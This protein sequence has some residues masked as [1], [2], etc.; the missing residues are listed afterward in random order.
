VP[1]TPDGYPFPDPTEPV[2]DGAGDIQ[3]LALTLRP[4]G[5]A[6][7]GQAP[8]VGTAP[9]ADEFWKVRQL[10]YNY[11]IGTDGN[12]IARVPTSFTK[13]IMWAGASNTDP[14]NGVGLFL[15]VP[16]YSTPA[17]LALW[18]YKRDG[19]AAIN[20]VTSMTCMIIGM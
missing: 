5:Q 7:G 6:F 12:G 17:E 18:I 16:A 3:Q 19:T 13:C 8:L 4:N 20:F 14:G 11:A 2:R 15:P 10:I 9:A 1:T